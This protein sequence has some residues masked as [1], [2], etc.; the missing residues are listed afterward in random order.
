MAASSGGEWFHEAQRLNVPRLR[1]ALACLPLLVTAAAGVRV[2]LPRTAARLPMS[3]GDLVFLAALSWLVFAW[4]VRARL[5]VATDA[6]GVTIR[7]SGLPWRERIAPAAWRRATL[8]TFDASREFGGYGLRRA[9]PVRACIAAGSTGVRL[10]LAD[11]GTL[12]I[13]TSRPADLLAAVNRA[14]GRRA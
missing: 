1:I 8:V 4:L 9:G 10:D 11:G 14:A 3:A 7:L 12:V 2:A 5:V 6:D 13:G